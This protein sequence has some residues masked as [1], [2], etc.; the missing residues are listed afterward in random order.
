MKYDKTNPL[1]GFKFK[2]TAYGQYIVTYQSDTDL[3]HKR[4]W[5]NRITDM[6]LIDATKNA[7]N[8]KKRDVDTLRRIVKNGGLYK[9]HKL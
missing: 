6:T 2:Q 7:V 9:L 3:S 4:F 5:M 1:K 8:V